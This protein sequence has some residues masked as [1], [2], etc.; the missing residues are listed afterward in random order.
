MILAKKML[1][2]KTI[3][4][5]KSQLAIKTDSRIISII[6]RMI[7]DYSLTTIKINIFV[8]DYQIPKSDEKDHRSL[9]EIKKFII[10]KSAILL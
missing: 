9:V 1:R 4:M 10:S 7:L 8:L 6:N 2:S 3:F 5:Q